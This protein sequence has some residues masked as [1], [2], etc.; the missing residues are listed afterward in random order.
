MTGRHGAS[1]VR[2]IDVVAGLDEWD[3][4]AGE[5]EGEERYL[6]PEGVLGRGETPTAVP[7]AAMM[8]VRGCGSIASGIGMAAVVVVAVGVAVA[9][10]VAVAVGVAV[11]VAVAV[12]LSVSVSVGAAA[13]P[14]E[15]D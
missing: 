6:V 7:S 5:G 15:R 1:A 8:P 9:V 14:D 13:A 11:A 10:A 2:G 3:R 12:T 4:E